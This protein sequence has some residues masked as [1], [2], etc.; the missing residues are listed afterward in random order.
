MIVANPRN[1]LCRA[2]ADRVILMHD[3][4]IVEML[5]Q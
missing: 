3:A 2:A 5:S 1:G 4:K